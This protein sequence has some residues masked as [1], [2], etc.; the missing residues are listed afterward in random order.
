MLSPRLSIRPGLIAYRTELKSALAITTL[1]NIITLTPGTLT[2]AVSDDRETLFIHALDIDHPEIVAATI[3]DS[4]EK[5]L[6]EL[7]RCWNL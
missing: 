5:R 7:E 6:L 4:F 2:L 1:A 3:R